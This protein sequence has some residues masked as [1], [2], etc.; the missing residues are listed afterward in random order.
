[1]SVGQEEI[2]MILLIV[3]LIIALVMGVYPVVY[4][5]V[6]NKCITEQWGVL[7]SIDSGITRVKEKNAN[8]ENFPFSVLNCVKCMWYDSLNSRWA[9]Q[10]EG[11]DELEYKDITYKLINVSENC[12]TCDEPKL[13]INNDGI[14]DKCANIVG[15]R[16]YTFEVGNDYVICKNC[17]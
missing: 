16:S 15:D 10:I 14:P 5:F 1:M 12:I 17:P 9:I 4:G 3:I 7:N 11:E 6:K 2:F 13:D 8:I